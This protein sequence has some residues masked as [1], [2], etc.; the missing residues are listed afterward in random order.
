MFYEITVG[1]MH[2]HAPPPQTNVVNG[3]YIVIL[4]WFVLHEFFIFDST[5]LIDNS[6]LQAV[7]M[8]S[9]ERIA[10]RSVGLVWR[11]HVTLRRGTVSVDVRTDT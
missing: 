2:P 6:V 10:L 3:A 8:G 5:Q 9:M 7:L 1:G 11:G 4:T